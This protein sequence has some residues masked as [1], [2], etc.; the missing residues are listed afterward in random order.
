MADKRVKIRLPRNR[1]GESDE[2]IVGVNGVLYRIKRGVEV[3]V[4]ESVVEVLQNADI[5]A[6]VLAGFIEQNNKT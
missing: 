4:P 6:D 1:S 5:A 2:Q 3:E